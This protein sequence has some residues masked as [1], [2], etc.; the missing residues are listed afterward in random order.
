MCGLWVDCAVNQSNLSVSYILDDE[1]G[2]GQERNDSVAEEG[3]IPFLLAQEI[4]KADYR[5]G[6]EDAWISGG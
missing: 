6:E 5:K 3:P 1:N 2:R 4:A